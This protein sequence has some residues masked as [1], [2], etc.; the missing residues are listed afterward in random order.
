MVHKEHYIVKL[1]KSILKI[2][3]IAPLCAG[4]T[5]QEG[6]PS[7]ETIFDIP[8]ETITGES[9]TLDSYRGKVLL[10]VNT[11]SKCGFTSQYEGLQSLYDQY[12]EQGLVV[13]GFPSNDFLRQEPG[14]NEEIQSFCKLNYGVTFPMFAKISVKGAAQHPLY[15]YLTHPESNPDYNGKISWNFNKFLIDRE[16]RVAARFGSRTKPRDK[17]LVAELESAL[18][19]T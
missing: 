18:Q 4:C 2:L 10:I 5:T 19:D 14:T 7:V 8:V 17:K 11:A 15:H 3:A 16:G 12:Q 9:T 6:A 13:L 1:V